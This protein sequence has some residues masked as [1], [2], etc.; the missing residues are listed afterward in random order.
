MEVGGARS[1]PEQTILQQTQQLLSQI[2]TIAEELGGML[3]F[4]A[5]MPKHFPPELKPLQITQKLQDYLLGLQMLQMLQLIPEHSVYAL[6]QPP[7]ARNSQ[8]VT[9]GTV[10]LLL[11]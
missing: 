4:E 8:M 7:A 6:R 9:M 11:D 10:L 1:S 3:E 2:K 5:F